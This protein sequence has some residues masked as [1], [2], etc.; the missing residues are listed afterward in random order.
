MQRG[1]SNA[2]ETIVQPRYLFVNHCPVAALVRVKGISKVFL[3]NFIKVK[4]Q[5]V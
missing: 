2:V 3:E 5:V 4:N 1:D